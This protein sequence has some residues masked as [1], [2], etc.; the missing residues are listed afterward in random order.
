[1]HTVLLQQSFRSVEKQSLMDDGS[2]TDCSFYFN[3]GPLLPP[4]TLRTF[5]DGVSSCPRCC[6]L[7]YVLCVA[8]EQNRQVKWI[9]EH[10]QAHYNGS[11][12]G[13]LAK[14][15]KTFAE[16]HREKPSGKHRKEE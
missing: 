6:L 7:S 10:E 5:P 4:Y 14:T 13:Y 3:L 12:K 9:S 11:A 2:A 1:M 8:V 15:E 16:L